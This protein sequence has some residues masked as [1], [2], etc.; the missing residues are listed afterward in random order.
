LGDVDDSDMLFLMTPDAFYG[1]L[2]ALLLIVVPTWHREASCARAAPPLPHQPQ[3]DDDEMM[4]RKH[5]AT[6]SKAILPG[7][8]THH[9]SQPKLIFFFIFLIDF[10]SDFQQSNE[11]SIYRK[12][13]VTLPGFC[14][15]ALM[16][17]VTCD[18]CDPVR[19]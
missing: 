7:C 8:Y 10:E 3:S 9:P 5:R 13:Y 1:F 18:P 14:R 2:R 6:S 4:M 16:Q 17:K 19:L 12:G 15:V 11:S